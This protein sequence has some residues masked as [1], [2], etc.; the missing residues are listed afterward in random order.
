MKS[1]PT[2]QSV[3][4]DGYTVH[5]GDTIHVTSDGDP[6]EEKIISACYTNKI[7]YTEPDSNGY[8]GAKLS[9]VYRHPELFVW[10]L[11]KLQSQIAPYWFNDLGK[12]WLN[13]AGGRILKSEGDA[14]S[15]VGFGQYKELDHTKTGLVVGKSDAG[16]LSRAG[17]F[18][19]CRNVDHENYAS[20]IL[21]SSGR[22]METGGWIRIYS[23]REWIATKRLSTDQ[24]TWLQ[25]RGYDTENY[26]SDLSLH[27]FEK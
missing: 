7:T 17:R 26:S 2:E 11:V 22:S 27:L 13:T 18:Y 12:Y 15:G 5:P 6:F 20:L 3:T 24:L 14:V 21:H 9:V 19:P 23:K 16:W 8:T 1:K 10:K 4:R 25:K